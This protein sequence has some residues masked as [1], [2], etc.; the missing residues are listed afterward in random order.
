MNKMTLDDAIEHCKEVASECY[1][2]CE[3]EHS[4][5]HDWLV[6][7]KEF[8]SK[9]DPIYSDDELE[10]DSEYLEQLDFFNNEIYELSLNVLKG[11]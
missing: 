6:E 4:Q 8:R 5:L 3:V 9:T 2:D 1:T 7:L 10:E 11:N